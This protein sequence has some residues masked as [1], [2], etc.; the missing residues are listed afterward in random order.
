[1]R[2]VYLLALLMTLTPLAAAQDNPDALLPKRQELESLAR[3]GSV[4]VDG[5]VCQNIVTPLAKEYMFKVDPRDEFLA[6]DNYDVDD[7][8]F[9]ITKKTL[10]RL[11]HLTSFPSDV[12]LWMPIDGHPG[13]I[14]I[15]VRNKNE[16]SQFWHWGDI[17]QDMIPPMET[18]L[19]TGQRVTVMDRPGWVSV[20]APVYNS[21]GDIVGLIEAVSRTKM[22][23]HDNVK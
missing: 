10:I 1:M 6:G 9:N 12:N 18:V 11:S 3:V 19:K 16:M 14:Q 2:T 20:L 7:V 13:K 4:M 22:D 17:Y 5:D 21:L 8:S 23:P 15:V